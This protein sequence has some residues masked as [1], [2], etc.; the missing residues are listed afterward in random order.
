MMSTV[1][2]FL[3]IFLIFWVILIRPQKQELERHQILVNNLKV[4][5][6]VVTAGGIFGTVKTVDGPVIQLD[7]G[8]GVK[9][10]IDRQKVQKTHDEFFL[11]HSDNDEKDD[12]DED[13]KS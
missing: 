4:G 7:V 6:K 10:K 2:M 3:I 8:K 5:D 9:I 11:D 1:L 13:K 12:E